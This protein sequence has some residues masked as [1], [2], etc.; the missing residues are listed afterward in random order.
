MLARS[1]IS[2]GSL[3]NIIDALL[4]PNAKEFDAA[5]FISFSRFTLGTKSIFP[6]F[7]FSVSRF[8]S[9]YPIVGGTIP[10]QTAL[11]VNTASIEP[12]APRQ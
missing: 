2:R 3:A 6:A 4:P 12:A 8:S 10:S 1:G 9:V 5:Y 7:S 11:T